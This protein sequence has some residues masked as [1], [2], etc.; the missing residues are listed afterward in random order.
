MSANSPQD[1]QAN[2]DAI[3][4]VRASEPAPAK[5]KAA[6]FLE[7]VEEDRSFDYEEEKAVLRRIDF[8]VLPILLWAYV[9][10]E[11]PSTV[12]D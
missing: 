11:L 1:A 10:A 9:S 5:D 4:E 6:L 7:S 8:R 3:T 12:P 2:P